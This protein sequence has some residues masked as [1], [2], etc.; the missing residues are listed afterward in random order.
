MNF[1][2]IAMAFKTTIV[3]KL[4]E[5]KNKEVDLF[6]VVVCSLR[7]STRRDLNT[8]YVDARIYVIMFDAVFSNKT[9][10][11]RRYK[12]FGNIITPRKATID[13]ITLFGDSN[14]KTQVRKKA[15]EYLEGLY[16]YCNKVRRGYIEVVK[17]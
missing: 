2:L 6:I 11:L 14:T 10:L 3:T 1:A 13:A 5:Q 7:V 15:K 9:V 8:L 12:T 4:N 17:D 16:R